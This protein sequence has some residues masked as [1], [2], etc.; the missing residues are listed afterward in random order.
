M[1]DYWADK[2]PVNIGQ[3]NFDRIHTISDT[4][5]PLNATN[6]GPL[7]LEGL[8]LIAQHIP[9]RLKHTPGCIQHRLTQ[10]RRLGLEIVHQDH[11]PASQ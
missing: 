2:L 4:H 3:N 9:T 8:N 11:A 5:R 10:F 7:L 6:Q 1:T